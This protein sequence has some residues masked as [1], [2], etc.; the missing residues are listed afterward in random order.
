LLNGFTS[1]DHNPGQ[2][3]M[4]QRFGFKCS[5]DASQLDLLYAASL[6]VAIDDRER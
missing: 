1:L 6:V 5:G 2:I 4:L 3:D